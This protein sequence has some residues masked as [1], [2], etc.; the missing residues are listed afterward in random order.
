MNYISIDWAI[1]D[2]I[3]EIVSFSL[4]TY[5]ERH[6]MINLYIQKYLVHP[7]DGSSAIDVSLVKKTTIDEVTKET[8][9]FSGNRLYIQRHLLL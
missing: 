9:G 1:N 7:E 2:R 6:R 3:D 8:E 4:P 5:S